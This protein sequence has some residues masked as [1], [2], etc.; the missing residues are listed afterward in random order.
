ME[1]I[2]EV[3]YP[4]YHKRIIELDKERGFPFLTRKEVMKYEKLLHRIKTG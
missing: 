1:N 4:E 2:L 3:L